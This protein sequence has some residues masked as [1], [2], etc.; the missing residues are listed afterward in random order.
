VVFRIGEPFRASDLVAKDEQAAADEIMRRV[1]ALLP[2][3]MRG[4]YT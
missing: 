4:V 2:A 3:E 1:A